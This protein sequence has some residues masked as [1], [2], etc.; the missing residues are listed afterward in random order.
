ML[1]RKLECC[2]WRDLLKPILRFPLLCVFFVSKGN[3][4][5]FYCQVTNFTTRNILLTVQF[6]N[7]DYWYHKPRKAFSEIYRRHFDLV[8]ELNVGIKSLLNY[9]DVILVSELKVSELNVRIKSLL[10]QG[11]SEPEFNGDLVYKFRKKYMLAMVL[12]LN[13]VK[14]FFDVY[15]LGTT[16]M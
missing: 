13:F 12:A 7:Q 8:S 15:R 1:P 9:I 16:K 14:S 11:I 6:L 3:P 10:Q 4:L 2:I 5:D